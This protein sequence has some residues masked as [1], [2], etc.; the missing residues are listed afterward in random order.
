MQAQNDPPPI[1]SGMR[2][3]RLRLRRS[4]RRLRRLDPTVR[5]MIWTALAGLIFALLNATMRWLAIDL[6]P[7]QAQFLRYLFGAVVMLPLII[8]SGLMAYQPKHW[9]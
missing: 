7:F 8:R 4:S 9:T 1:D 3:L 6:H 2:S 5:G